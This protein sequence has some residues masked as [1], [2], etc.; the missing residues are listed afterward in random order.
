MQNL[1]S[2]PLTKERI[3]DIY[4]NYCNDSNTFKSILHHMS[5]EE[6]DIINNMVEEENNNSSPYS[7][8]MYIME[9]KNNESMAYPEDAPFTAKRCLE[10]YQIYSNSFKPNETF[11][12][13]MEPAERD[14]FYNYV[15]LS[16]NSI[17][18]DFIN[19]VSRA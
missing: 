7:C 17:Y 12:D 6:Q 2:S 16:T 10:I 18:S 1:E 11:L 3:N 14:K 13:Y 15:L 5:L 4:N 9:K 19:L 8:F